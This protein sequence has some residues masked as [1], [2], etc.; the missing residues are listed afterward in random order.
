[1]WLS[2]TVL[3]GK[4]VELVPLAE[5]HLSDLAAAV[6]DGELWRLWVTSVPKPGEIDGWY[7]AA[8]ARRDEVGDLPFAVIDR[9]TGRAIGTTRLCNP[10]EE[11]RRVEI[12][13]TW[14]AA[15]RQRTGV[16]TEA[17]RLLLTHAFETLRCIAVEFRA[18]RLNRRSRAAIERLG[19][20]LDGILR[21]HRILA[22]GTYRD[23]AVYSILH[24]EWPAVKAHITQL[25]KR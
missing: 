7:R 1:M 24:S 3:V 14:Y 15:S 25:S 16:N 20:H 4:G 18:H 10:D 23:T 5:D 21:N 2:N 19:A 9:R 17:K 11:N 6:N 12:G 13:Y 8:M 22:D